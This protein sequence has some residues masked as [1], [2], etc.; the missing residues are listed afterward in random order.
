MR[1][2]SQTSESPPAQKE[3]K[4]DKVKEKLHMKK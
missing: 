1:K 2:T 3:S 4:I